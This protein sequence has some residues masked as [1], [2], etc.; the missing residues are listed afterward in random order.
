MYESTNSRTYSKFPIQ[1]ESS[2]KYSTKQETTWEE[3]LLLFGGAFFK[4]DGQKVPKNYCTN[5]KED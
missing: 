2:L 1:K 5:L 3:N 4:L